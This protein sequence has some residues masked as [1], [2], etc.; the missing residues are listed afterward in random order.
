VI[1]FLVTWDVMSGDYSAPPYLQ[2]R[3]IYNKCD[4]SNI[5]DKRLRETVSHVDL[6][7]VLELACLC[8]SL[9]PEDR[10]KINKVVEIL[11]ALAQSENSTQSSS[12]IRTSI[13]APSEDSTSSPTKE[14]DDLCTKTPKLKING[15]YF[16]FEV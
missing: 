3:S 10:P 13:D 6:D 1:T 16:V 14:D 9:T 8:V 7:A 5:V 12:S 11:E 2:V 4:S 15:E